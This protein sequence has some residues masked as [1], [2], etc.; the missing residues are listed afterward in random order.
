MAEQLKLAVGCR[1]VGG[2]GVRRRGEE[3]RGE[4]RRGEETVCPSPF[5]CSS[6]A[7][8]SSPFGRAL[9]GKQASNERQRERERERETDIERQRKRHDC[10]IQ[11]IQ[12][13]CHLH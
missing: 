12:T 11:E 3:R 10:V 13:G 1:G 9:R 2:G 5:L 8:D 6:V 4:E 7:P